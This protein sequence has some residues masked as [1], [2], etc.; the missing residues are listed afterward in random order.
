MEGSIV[1]LIISSALPAS[2]SHKARG[3]HWLPAAPG[4]FHRGTLTILQGRRDAD[5]Y[6]VDEDTTEALG[7]A[8]RFLLAKL[9]ADGDVYAVTIGR[10][11]NTC[12]GMFCGKH[13]TC[14]HRDAVADL[15]RQGELTPVCGECAGNGYVPT[16]DLDAVPCPVCTN[17]AAVPVMRNHIT[18]PISAKTSRGVSLTACPSTS[19][20]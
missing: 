6:A 16:A 20:A 1:C 7:T 14:K 19:A 3:Y 15:L 10:R 12:S 13:P 11:G 17:P 5:S 4:S 9:D 18:A 8:R 2:K